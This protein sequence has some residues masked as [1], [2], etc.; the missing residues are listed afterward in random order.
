MYFTLEINAA[1]KV[2]TQ[3][4]TWANK[5]PTLLHAKINK[6]RSERNDKLNTWEQ[7]SDDDVALFSQAFIKRLEMHLEFY[8]SALIEIDYTPL[9]LLAEITSNAKLSNKAFFERRGMPFTKGYIEIKKGIVTI[10]RD[11][12]PVAT[13]YQSNL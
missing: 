12:K 1:L 13:L 3:H 7:I 8:P 6:K 2:F 11:N 9:T 10:K 5:T 4:I